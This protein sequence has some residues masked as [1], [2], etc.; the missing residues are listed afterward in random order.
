MKITEASNI[1]GTNTYTT[2]VITPD[3]LA[4]LHEH[5]MLNATFD[6]EEFTSRP[7]RVQVVVQGGPSPEIVEIAK[8]P[9]HGLHGRRRECYVCQGPVE[10]VRAVIT[11]YG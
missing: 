7:R 1:G 3:E 10:Q 2:I 5:R 6:T 8:C 4:A 9:E 11:P